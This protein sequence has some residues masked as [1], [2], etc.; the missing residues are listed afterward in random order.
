MNN[1]EFINNYSNNNDSYFDKFHPDDS[2]L[3]WG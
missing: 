2:H 1:K 3:G